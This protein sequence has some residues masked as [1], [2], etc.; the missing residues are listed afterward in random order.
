MVA[1]LIALQPREP[2]AAY[3]LAVAGSVAFSIQTA[4]LDALI[5]PAYFPA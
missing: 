2:R 4:L 5:W 1:A 3:A